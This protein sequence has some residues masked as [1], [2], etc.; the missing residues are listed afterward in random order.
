M[1]GKTKF[2]NFSSSSIFACFL[3]KKKSSEV[4]VQ[5]K[6][7]DILFW[8]LNLFSCRLPSVGAA[9]L[10]QVSALAAWKTS[11]CWRPSWG[12]IPAATSCM[13]WTPGLRWGLFFARGSVKIQLLQRDLCVFRWAL[14]SWLGFASWMCSQ[15]KPAK[16]P[17]YVPVNPVQ[18]HPADICA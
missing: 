8:G 9:S 11:R 15:Q 10:C 5:L 3:L 17:E 7:V 6:K 12:P 4:R 16:H 14:F 18:Y 1:Q 2:H 13:W